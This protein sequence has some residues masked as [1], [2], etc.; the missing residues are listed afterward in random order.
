M[1]HDHLSQGSQEFRESQESQESHSIDYCLCASGAEVGLAVDV[2]AQLREKGHS[3]RVVSFPS[4][5][6]FNQQS[7]SYKASVLGEK[8]G[9]YWVIEAQVG[10]GWHQYVGRDA[11]FVTMETFGKSAPSPDLAKDFGFTVD[12]I[13]GGILRQA[14]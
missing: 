13:V 3:V 2:A 12:Q 11:G 6:L 7:E 14:L 10:F 5:E 1:R 9:Q 4:F 8:V